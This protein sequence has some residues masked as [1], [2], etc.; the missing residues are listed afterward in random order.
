[1][2]LID[3]D[4]LLEK[5]LWYDNFND[6]FEYVPKEDVENAPTVGYF[7]VAISRIEAEKAVR[8]AFE[9]VKCEGLTREEVNNIIFLAIRDTPDLSPRLFNPYKE[10]N[11][12]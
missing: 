2:R 5:A 12:E 6:I 11:D 4:A 3:A 7:D 8:K 9:N 10:K 1:M